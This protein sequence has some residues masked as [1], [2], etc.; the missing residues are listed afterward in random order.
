MPPLAN[1]AEPHLNL[2]GVELNPQRNVT[3]DWVARRNLGLTIHAIPSREKTPIEVPLGSSPVAPEWSPDGKWVAFIATDESGAWLY[4]ADSRTGKSRRLLSRPL[5]AVLET[6]LHW[7]SDSQ[8][9]AV[10]AVPEKRPPLPGNPMLPTGP[11]V[12]VAD[13]ATNAIRTFP[14]RLEND[15]EA[16]TLRHFITGQTVVVDMRGKAVEV[17]VPAMIQNLDPSP[18]FRSFRMTLVEDRFLSIY[19]FFS[20]PR[21]T[22]LWDEAGKELAEI[23]KGQMPDAPRTVVQDEKR[24]L[25]WDPTGNGMLF[26]QRTAADKDGKRQDRIMRWKHPY[27]KDDAETLWTSATDISSF[28]ILPDGK[29]A[30]VT[31]TISGESLWSRAVFGGTESTKVMGFKPSEFYANPGSPVSKPGPVAGSVLRT[32]P[33][34]ASFYLSGV[35]YSKEP[36]KTAPRPFMDRIAFADGKKERVWQ[37]PTETFETARILDDEAR[38]LLISQ[39]SPTQ[40]PNDF[41]AI[42]SKRIAL[43]ENQDMVPEV[44]SLRRER[45]LVTRSDGFKFWVRVTLPKYAVSGEGRKAFFWFYPNEV[46]SQTTYD[47]SQRTRNINLFRR[48]SPA[49]PELLCLLGYVVVEPDVPIVGPAERPNDT[50]VMQLRNSLYAV[51]DELDRRRLIDRQL[52]S[53]GGHSYG[54]FSTAHAMTQTPFFK[55][56]IAGSGNYNR[57]LTPFGFQGEPRRMWESRDMYM[58]MSPILR[59]DQITGALLMTH[60]AEDQNVGTF[61]INSI[62]MFD[63]LEALGKPAALYLY[64]YEDHGQIARETRLDMWARWILWLEEHVK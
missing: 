25:G 54:A 21:K 19:P 50:Y 63:A 26:L 64:P 9:I 8:R 40:A 17:G 1:L 29:G 22:V 10:V 53:I 24:S 2:A 6:S 13:K 49:S 39:Q 51:I 31:Q 42:G 3:R 5:L 41:L 37:S 60:G 18:D 45:V 59:A 4:L 16:K 33:D 61:P 11:L 7:S 48:T 52:L 30:L 43:T 20:F 47:E 15:D 35:E 46:R 12:R 23:Q 55:A 57:T 34:G 28:Q 27:G 38:T 14:D 56:G 58:D 44:S 62:R 36:D 32:T